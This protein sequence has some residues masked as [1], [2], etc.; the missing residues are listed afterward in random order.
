MTQLRIVLGKDQVG[1]K[2][3]ANFKRHADNMRKA[4]RQ[5]AQETADF[6]MQ[7][8]RA[9]IRQAGNFGARWTDGWQAIVTEGG[10]FIKIRVTMQVTYWTVFQDGKVIHGRPMLWIPLP[11][12]T[13]AKGVSARNYPGQLFRVNRRAG[14]PLLMAAGKP[15]QAKYSGHES[16]TLPKKFHLREM[17]LLAS[18]A[19]PA[20]FRR[21]FKALT[22]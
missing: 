11:W 12:A 6:I 2:L 22:K 10:G 15:A 4:L 13:D 8:G 5:T 3:K 7:E 9:D 18:R 21:N 14:S 19:M 16:V 20:L 1:P 17:I